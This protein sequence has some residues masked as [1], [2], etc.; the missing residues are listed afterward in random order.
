M[1]TLNIIRFSFELH[2][3]SSEVRKLKLSAGYLPVLVPAYKRPEYLSQVLQA[4]QAAE[5]IDEVRAY[6]YC[7]FFPNSLKLSADCC[8][9]VPGRLGSR[10]GSIDRAVRE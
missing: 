1:E 7:H 4:M 3:V 9:R 6:R 5:G 10:D 8:D 2:R